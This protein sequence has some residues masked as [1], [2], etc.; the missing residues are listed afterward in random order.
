MA[1]SRR[2]TGRCEPPHL[3]EPHPTR[4]W[5][6]F[7]KRLGTARPCRPSRR[8][9]RLGVHQTSTP[10]ARASFK[11][12][13]AASRAPSTFRSMSFQTIS[14]MFVVGARA[15]SFQS[16]G[17]RSAPS[18]RRTSCREPAFSTCRC[19]RAERGMVGPCRPPGSAP[20]D[21]GLGYVARMRDEVRPPSADRPRDEE[22]GDG[23]AARESDTL[24]PRETCSRSHFGS[25]L[26]LPIYGPAVRR[27]SVARTLADGAVASGQRSVSSRT[28]G[29]LRG[30][31]AVRRRQYG[32]RRRHVA[33]LSDGQ[34]DGRFARD[35]AHVEVLGEASLRRART[36][37]ERCSRALAEPD[38]PVLAG[39]RGRLQPEPPYRRAH[40][41]RGFRDQGARDRV[42]PGPRVMTFTYRGTAA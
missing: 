10:E 25:G 33:S 4:V 2:G 6:A 12:R 8:R 30:E 20:R 15:C 29:V 27:L 7:G 5:E 31:P 23:G 24:A 13:S 42:L 41:R 39:G 40:S 26:N 35:E 14:R 28:S 18:V 22:R 3:N 19:S 32:H 1:S 34:T 37:S 38:Q 16:G 11:A 21:A 36:I 17:W 9:A